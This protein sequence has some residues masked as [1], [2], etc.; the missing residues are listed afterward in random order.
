MLKKD[1][2][3][4]QSAVAARMGNTLEE[5]CQQEDGGWRARLGQCGTSM[6][7]LSAYPLANV[8][9]AT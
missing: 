6:L 7:T 8:Q 1:F 3:S 2:P 5:H 9:Y 4:A